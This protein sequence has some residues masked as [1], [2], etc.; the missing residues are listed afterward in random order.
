MCYK[1]KSKV[2]FGIVRPAIGPVNKVSTIKGSLPEVYQ[3]L[4][5]AKDFLALCIKQITLCK[6]HFIY[7]FTKYKTENLKI[8]KVAT[9]L[10]H[11]P[12]ILRPNMAIYYKTDSAY[13]V[14]QKCRYNLW[15]VR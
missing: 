12:S 4:T 7:C 8:A 3:K 1:R 14:L 6:I 2:I 15:F 9:R 13:G 10:E 11:F 5:V